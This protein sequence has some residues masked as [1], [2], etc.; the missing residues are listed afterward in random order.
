MMMGE[1]PPLPDELIAEL[2]QRSATR[3]VSRPELDY[4]FY[5]DA[6]LEY[7]A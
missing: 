7:C 6:C 2:H 4:S 1:W 3:P 5:Q